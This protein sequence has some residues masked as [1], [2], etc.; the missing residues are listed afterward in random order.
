VR[1][2]RAVERERGS[3]G[4]GGVVLDREVMLDSA[5]G[6]A[7]YGYRMAEAYFADGFRERYA[8]GD[9]DECKRV[10]GE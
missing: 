1:G 3:G 6:F 4:W 8:S 2:V 9:G 7:G 10:C 5:A